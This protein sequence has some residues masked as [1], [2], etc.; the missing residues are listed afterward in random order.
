[1]PDRGDRALEQRPR[2]PVVTQHGLVGVELDAVDGW[3]LVQLRDGML[4]KIRSDRVDDFY[5]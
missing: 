3:S 5:G 1:M 4:I 2:R